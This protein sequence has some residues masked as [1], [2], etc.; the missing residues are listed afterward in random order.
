[1]QNKKKCQQATLWDVM[2]ISAY[3]M[4][5]ALSARAWFALE[6]C[7]HTEVM[8]HVCDAKSESGDMCMWRFGMLRVLEASAK[9]AAGG[10]ALSQY[11]M[12]L[13]EAV[14][15]GPYGVAGGTGE[16]AD[17]VPQFAVASRTG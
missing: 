17:V 4:C 15:K 14:S 16:P 1:V 3:R 8:A 5:T 11:V 9:K 13:H 10:S 2:Q 7:Q 12:R 6:I